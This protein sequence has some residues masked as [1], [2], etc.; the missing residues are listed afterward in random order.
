M[1]NQYR[2][3]DRKAPRYRINRLL[4]LNQDLYERFIEKFPEHKGL[5]PEDFKKIVK[6]MNRKIYENAVESRDG[7]ELPEG[8][9]YVFVGT[10][11]PRKKPVEDPIASMK[12]G[13]KISFRNFESDNYVAKIFYTNFAS[14]YR[15]KDR[16]IW[17]FVAYRGF[18]NL[19]SSTYAENWKKYLQVDNMQK[20]SKVFMARVHRNIGSRINKIV[21]DEYNEFAL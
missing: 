17:K 11:P 12:Y 15:F 7:T 3:P 4:L 21:T 18:K 19:V 1:S 6:V 14:K 9:G 10:C 8:L 16:E 5:S 13:R 20:V 2:E